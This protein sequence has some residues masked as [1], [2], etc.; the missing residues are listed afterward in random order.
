MRDRAGKEEEE[1]GEKV[2]REL[3]RSDEVETHQLGG[4]VEDGRFE[5]IKESPCDE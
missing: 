3:R 1:R 2:S 5:K 4:K